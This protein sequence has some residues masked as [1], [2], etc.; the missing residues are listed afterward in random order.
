MYTSAS[1]P[2]VHTLRYLAI[3]VWQGKNGADYQRRALSGSGTLPC[4]PL[5]VNVLQGIYMVH[6]VC[7]AWWVQGI[8]VG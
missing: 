2:K 3:D 4:N 8:D 7:G 5:Y 1:Q 6:T